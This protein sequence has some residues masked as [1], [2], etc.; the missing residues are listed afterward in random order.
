MPIEI[1]ACSRRTR[2][3]PWCSSAVRTNFLPLFAML[4]G[5]AKGRRIV[6]YNSMKPPEASGCTPQRYWT[7]TQTNWHDEC[8][9]ALID[10]RVALPG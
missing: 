5:G 8:A 6:F 4:T 7:K 10:G 2:T 3:N 9:Q 1:S